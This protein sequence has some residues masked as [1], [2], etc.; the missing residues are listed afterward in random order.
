MSVHRKILF[1]RSGGGM[2]GLDI[3]AGIWSA[4]TQCGIVS[5]ANSGT[6][7]GAIV[8]AMDSTGWHPDNAVDYLRLH[9]DASV[10][11]PHAFWYLRAHWLESIHDN[12]RIKIVL[13]G[14]LPYAWYNVVKPFSAWATRLSDCA[15]INVA[16]PEI[17]ATPAD[18]VL[19]SMS[20]CGLFPSVTLL[21]GET[22]IDGGVRFNLPLT[23]DWED[24]DDVYL[25]IAS[26]RPA[27]YPRQNGI[28]TNLIRNVQAL[29][30]D[31]ID[32]ILRTTAKAPTVRVI[33]PDCRSDSG[34]LHFDHDLIE[35]AYL[36]TMNILHNQKE[37]GT[38]K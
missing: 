10:R 4:L 20:I 15:Y 34:L 33:W 27:D 5:T 3:H 38:C 8:S 11:D 12:A 14:A 31:Q 13:D 19:A 32:D 16:R 17:A 25:L 2:P 29:A 36:K 21:D 7:A 30:F 28:L 18:A 23:L 35:D 26:P 37:Y 9:D 6:S 22:Y 1:V 24:Y